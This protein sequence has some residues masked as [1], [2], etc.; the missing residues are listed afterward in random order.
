MDRLDEKIGLAIVRFFFQRRKYTTIFPIVHSKVAP[1]IVSNGCEPCPLAQSSQR[2]Y[3]FLGVDTVIIPPYY[4][5]KEKFNCEAGTG[6]ATM[7]HL[8]HGTAGMLLSLS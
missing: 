4:A 1:L 8:M 7:M 2:N 6:H 5:Q 3:V